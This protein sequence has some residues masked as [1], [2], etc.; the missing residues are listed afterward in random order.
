VGYSLDLFVLLELLIPGAGLWYWMGAL[1][2]VK[3]QQLMAGQMEWMAVAG[4]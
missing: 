3:K 1:D 2:V 4:T